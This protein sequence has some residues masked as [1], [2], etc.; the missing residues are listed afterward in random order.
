[1]TSNTVLEFRYRLKWKHA[2]FLIILGYGLFA[3]SLHEAIYY[4]DTPHPDTPSPLIMWG[5]AIVMFLLGSMGVVGVVA[6][7][8]IKPKITL[9][10][11][12]LTM[13]GPVWSPQP[14]THDLTTMVSNKMLTQYGAS[15]FEVK[16]KNSRFVVASTNF[17]SNEEFL[18]FVMAIT[19]ENTPE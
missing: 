14:R 10:D 19:P 8:T 6:R 12:T 1:M 7:F 16:L 9:S 17:D 3:F 5:M 11:H 18:R 13:P 2:L 15:Y 4:P